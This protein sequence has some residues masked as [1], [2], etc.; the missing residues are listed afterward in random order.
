VLSEL[1]RVAAH[2]SDAFMDVGG[3]PASGIWINPPQHLMVKQLHVH[4]SPKLP[5]FTQVPLPL[6]RA[7]HASYAKAMELFDKVTKSIESKLG[8]ST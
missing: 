1:A 8:P 4:V 5:R 7:D 3:C 2:V 6:V